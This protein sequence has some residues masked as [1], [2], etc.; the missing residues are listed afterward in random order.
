MTIEQI[1]II[2]ILGFSMFMFIW[3]KLRFDVIAFTSLIIAVVLGLVPSNIAFLGFGES[4]VI[5]VIMVFVI[6]A[7]IEKARILDPIVALTTPY[8][9]NQVM[10]IGIITGL[11]T[12][13]SAFMNDVGALSL[14]MPVALQTARAQKRSPSLLL[15]PLSFGTLLG[16]TLTTIGTPPNIIISNYRG[17]VM[18]E[19]Y[20]L[21]AFAPATGVVAIVGVAFIVLIGWRFIP[22]NRKAS[23]SEEFFDVPDY[24]IEVQVDEGSP[25]IDQSVRQ[26][27]SEQEDVSVIGIV[28]DDGRKFTPRRHD[29]ILESDV[30]ILRTDPEI[31]TQLFDK[32]GMKL[33]ESAEEYI[34]HLRSDEVG[35]IEAVVPPGA[36]VEGKTP[37]SLSLRQNYGLNLVAV[38]RDGSPIEGR[39]SRVRIRQGD[40]LLFQGEKSTMYENIA[41]IGCMPLAERDIAVRKSGPAILALVIFLGAI[42][43]N[44]FGLLPIH[45]SFSLAVLLMLAASLITVHDVYKA[46]DWP[47]LVLLGSMIPLG[48]ALEHTGGTTLIA[49]GIL[50]VAQGVPVP[51]ILGL[52][53]FLTMTLSDV[54]NNTATAVVMGPIAYNIALQLGVNPDPFLISVAIGASCAFLT[55]V[56]HHNNM[57][58]MNAGGYRFGDYWKMGLPLEILV[59]TMSVIMLMIVWPL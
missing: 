44:L 10:H 42:S 28:R 29:K 39:I 52:V 57:L 53:L 34:E 45:I 11:G 13:L 21:L 22:I 8:M 54:M 1:Q 15:M 24:I 17:K 31:F 51:V 41:T 19:T 18:G 26:F 59:V 16:G 5:T 3:G 38:A 48:E 37:R 7:A 40:V 56:G 33:K 55:P 4:A 25:V 36:N 14:L 23:T 6:S 30:L 58:V 43:M 49:E 50:S 32:L 2:S 20:D 9:K 35:F 27:E 46:I 12:F 47:V